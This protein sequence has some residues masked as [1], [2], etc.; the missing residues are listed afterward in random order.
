MPRRHAWADFYREETMDILREAHSISSQAEADYRYL[1][2]HAET[3]FDLHDTCAYVRKQLEGIGC[4][5]EVCGKCGLTAI[6]GDQSKGKCILLRADMDALPI[7]E[8]ADIDFCSSNG[9]M[10]ACGHD[11][12]T[13]MLLGAARLLKAHEHKLNGAVRLMFQ[14]AEEILEG[15]DDM[16]RG[17]ILGNPEPDAAVMIHVIPGIPLPAGTVIIPPSGT[18]APA[19]CYFTIRIKGVG[20]HGSSPAA[21]IDPIS[22]A[23]HALIALHEIPARELSPSEHAVLTVGSI[24]GG[25]AANAIPD[26]VIMRGTLR[27][28]DDRV[29]QRIMERIRVIAESISTAF[30]TSAEVT[31]DSSC[32]TLINDSELCRHSA[33]ALRELL[34][35]SGCL[36]AEQMQSSGGTSLN[37]SEDFAYVSHKIPSLMLALA[38]GRPDDGYNY[39]LHH[40]KAR[41]DTSVLPV[42]SAVYAHTAISWL[43]S[44]K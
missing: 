43:E 6:I 31:F 24:N 30:R 29:C 5:P 20:C 17:G 42:G 36:S 33:E 22:C 34:G 8:Q 7:Q 15:A 21:G 9:N 16:I 40:P 19:A 14:P 28:F 10:H 1:H 41:F 23:A 27:A 37:G 38:A 32:P 35:N 2:T 18:G 12:H 25:T 13:A 11:M 39:G 44:H 26:E 3:G 4:Q